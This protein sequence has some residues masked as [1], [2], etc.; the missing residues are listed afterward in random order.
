VCR[1]LVICGKLHIEVPAHA[2]SWWPGRWMF[3]NR[4]VPSRSDAASHRS[5]LCHRINVRQWIRDTLTEGALHLS[6][7]RAGVVF[8][9]TFPL[10]SYLEYNKVLSIELSHPV[11]EAAPSSS[12]SGVGVQNTSRLMYGEFTQYATFCSSRVTEIQQGIFLLHCDIGLFLFIISVFHS[13]RTCP[14]I[15]T[16]YGIFSSRRLDLWYFQWAKYH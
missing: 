4:S 1:I 13:Y 7:C 11:R 9:I 5:D 14:A 16:A 3:R 2:V 12:V 8:E 10:A 15:T 6:I